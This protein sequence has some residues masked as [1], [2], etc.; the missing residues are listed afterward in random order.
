MHIC[1]S[2]Y[3]QTVLEHVQDLLDIVDVHT[4]AS[5]VLTQYYCNLVNI[6]VYQATE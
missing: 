2:R 3:G 1:V 6:S 4:T 5:I